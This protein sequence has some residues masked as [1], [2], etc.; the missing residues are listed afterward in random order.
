[1]PVGS[2]LCDLPRAAL[3]RLQADGLSGLLAEILPRHPFYA[4]KLDGF[5]AS[6]LCFPRDLERM[7]FTTRA[8]LLAAQAGLPPHGGLITYPFDR[9]VRMHQTSGTSTGRPLRWYDTQESW[10]ALLDGWVEKFHIGGILPSD[11][12]F[13][14]FSFGPFIGFWSAFEAGVKYGCLCLP[15]GGMS[16]T[17]RL[18]FLLDNWPTVV[19]CTPTYALR[20]AEVAQQEGVD[21]RAAGVRALVVAGEPGG[22]IPATRGRIESGW[23]AR[24]LD[25]NGMTET[26]PLGFECSA[27]PGGLHLLETACWPEVV[28]PESGKP[29]PPGTT[30]ELVITTFRRVA[31]PLI[32]YRTGDLVCADPT[33]CPCGRGL[34]RLKG[35]ISSRVDDMV[36]VK[37]NNLHPGALQTILHRFADVAEFLVEIDE[38]ASLAVLRVSVEPAPGADGAALAGRIERAIRD[39]LLFRAEVRAVA[40]GTLPRAEMKARRWLR[41]Q[42]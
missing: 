28:D 38:T 18:R 19:F 33:P 40:P 14:P 30:G 8:E 16:S 22:S 27:A 25:H 21:L 36:V 41:R 29:I 13:F 20:L 3:D 24:V 17:A 12:L 15:G 23:G 26:G 32:R 10:Q 35:G 4:R 5:S 34:M 9:Y 1:M 39:E 42:A 11:R 31:S 2:L 7:P 37:G 6:R